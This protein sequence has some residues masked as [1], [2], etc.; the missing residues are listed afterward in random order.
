MEKTSK[1]IFDTIPGYKRA[2]GDILRYI[3]Y[4]KKGKWIIFGLKGLTDK[5]STIL[6]V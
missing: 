6:Y 1:L 2:I 5:D 3:Y 4:E